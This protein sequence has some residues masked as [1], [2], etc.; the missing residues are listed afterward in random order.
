MAGTLVSGQANV[1][2]ETLVY[3]SQR[4]AAAGASPVD[5]YETRR[6]AT[7]GSGTIFV[8][9][10]TDEP[11]HGIS[12][13]VVESGGGVRFVD[14]AVLNPATMSPGIGVDERWHADLIR[15]GDVSDRRVSRLEGGALVG[16]AGGG[17]GIGPAL[18]AYDALYEATGGFLFATVDFEVDNPL[19]SSE[20]TLEIGQN[21]L[22]GA[23]GAL[24]GNIYLG[25]NDG[26]VVN[27]AQRSGQ[28]IDMEIVVAARLA[29]DFND[30][31]WVDGHDA[32][33][34]QRGFG[35]TAGI[36]LTGDANGDGMVDLDDWLLWME[37]FGEAA[38]LAAGTQVPEPESLSLVLWVALLG[39][40]SDGRNARSRR[41][42][43]AWNAW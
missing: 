32:L 12:L 24:Q 19:A 41:R 27:V 23:G 34:W 9:V 33:T 31:G 5:P 25:V 7:A 37:Q 30:D 16:L 13:D 10:K 22:G 3:L 43:V 38:G 1:R 39:V 36:K 26:P 40:G 18:V 42:F 28:S 6:V 21:R 4:G 11:V 14:A 20:V 35:E 15:N 17:A 8:W 2:G 29:A